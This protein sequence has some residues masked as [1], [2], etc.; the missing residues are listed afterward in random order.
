MELDEQGNI[1]TVN[2]QSF[3]EFIQD[4][5]G[6]MDNE[7]MIAIKQQVTKYYIM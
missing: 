6:S 5:Y 4:T 1:V 2:E 3:D 7:D